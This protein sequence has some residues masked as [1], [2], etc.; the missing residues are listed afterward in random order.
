M[1]L[2]VLLVSDDPAMLEMLSAVLASRR[3][4]I[5]RTANTEDAIQFVTG[6]PPHIVILDLSGPRSDGQETCRALR[7]AS[8][9]PIL[10]LSPLN[11]PSVIARMLDAGA[12]DYLVKPVPIS[13]VMAHL[14]KLA[15]R[16]GALGLGQPEPPD[17]IR[18]TQPL[19][20]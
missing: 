19:V 20:S 6:N 15:R 10:V 9:V 5:T 11:E 16:T 12:D 17:W 13:V 14:K 7:L 1:N 18:D 3:F 8:N 4:D 2:S